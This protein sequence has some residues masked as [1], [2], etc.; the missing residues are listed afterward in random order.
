MQYLSLKNGCVHMYK[1]TCNISQFTFKY[2]VYKFESH[3]SEIL[4]G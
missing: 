2:L 3:Q 1:W 4:N